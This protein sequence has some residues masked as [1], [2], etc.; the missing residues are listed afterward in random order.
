M[1]SLIRLID[2]LCFPDYNTKKKAAV[3]HDSSGR[4]QIMADT[5]KTIWNRNF[6]LL[7]IVNCIVNFGHSMVAN[8]L[9]KYL[10]SIGLAGTAI[11]FIIS[12]FSFTAL[13]F[14]PVTGPLI[15][16]WDK[17]K[18][19]MMMLAVLI[20]SFAGYT[21]F[22]IMSVIVICRLLQGL[23]QGC[24]SALALTMATDSVPREKLGSG[25]SLYG[26]GAVL[27][28]ALGPGL[29]LS[30]MDRFGYSH[31]FLAP[32]A[33]LLISLLI[34]TLLQSTYVPGTR[35][36]FSLSGM[37]C[38]EAFLPAFLTM[39]T[40]L[41]RAGLYTFL[42]VYIT[43]NRQ[44][45]GMS[46]YY[47]VNALAMIVSRPFFGRLADRKGLHIALIPSLSFFA[48]A[49]LLTALCRSTA[50]LMVI[51]VLNA[52][53]FGSAFSFEQALCMKVAPPEHRGAASTTSFIGVD[54][55]DLIGPI[56]CGAL[57]DWFGYSPMFLFMLIPVLLSAFL[58]FL[59]VPKHREI[60]RP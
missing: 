32:L 17:K 38:R 21:F 49:L 26:I 52:F 42:I 56:I 30:I 24:I 13:G 57:V 34:S 20:L 22:P 6:I 60:L 58:L 48:V 50:M 11:G 12:L 23:G 43:E 40:C 1:A 41:V 27:A 18:L 29:G 2:F 46:W 28:S 39:L 35:I 54:L 10:D 5:P 59:W 19:Y 14:R 37:L 4:R 33:L 16:G 9:P 7:F 36:R 15:D 8:L 53:G 3:L 31:A 44:I 45:E 55:G 51:A 47:Y 25:L